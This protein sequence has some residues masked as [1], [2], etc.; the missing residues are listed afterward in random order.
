MEYI[1]LLLEQTV[2]VQRYF[3]EKFSKRDSK[4]NRAIAAFVSSFARMQPVQ[5]MNIIGPKRIL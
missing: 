5:G 4:S 1:N 3:K 2:Q